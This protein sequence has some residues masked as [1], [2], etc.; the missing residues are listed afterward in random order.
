MLFFNPPKCNE[1]KFV[2]FEIFEIV[3][4]FYTICPI[5]C[6]FPI[7]PSVRL[8]LV[9]RPVGWSVGLSL[10]SKKYGSLHFQAP[11]LGSCK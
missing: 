1:Q 10:F 9:G 6:D 3:A 11:F 8:L 2:I 5:L 7:N 4:C